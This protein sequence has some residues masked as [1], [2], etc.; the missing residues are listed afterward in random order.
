V[1]TLL[2]IVVLSVVSN[3]GLW[4]VVGHD[5]Y[6]DIQVPVPYVV[7]VPDMTFDSRGFA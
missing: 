6:H 1:L 7:L 4:R 3:Y 2:L 5:P